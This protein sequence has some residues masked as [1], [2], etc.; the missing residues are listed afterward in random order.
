MQAR[1]FQD[2]AVVE[3]CR[4]CPSAWSSSLSAA[5]NIAS[6]SYKMMTYNLVE[7]EGVASLLK[8]NGTARQNEIPL[9]RKQIFVF[10]GRLSSGT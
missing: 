3:H 8:V 10:I 9:E 5:W 4:H 7:P 2:R 6:S 1:K